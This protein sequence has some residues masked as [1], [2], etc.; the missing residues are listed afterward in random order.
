MV[1]SSDLEK[2]RFRKNVTSLLV[3]ERVGSGKEERDAVFYTISL[4]NPEIADNELFVLLN[5]LTEGEAIA[6]TIPL[7][8][9]ARAS[10][11]LS[12]IMRDL[13]A[14]TSVRVTPGTRLYLPNGQ[15]LINVHGEV[16]C[17]ERGCSIHHPSNHHMKQFS[18]VYNH[19]DGWMMRVCDH[20]ITASGPLMTRSYHQDILKDAHTLDHACDGCCHAPDRKIEQNNDN[21]QPAVGIQD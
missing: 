1:T 10:K 5:Q 16:D 17:V 18:Q 6:Y 7:D 21:E 4:E 3:S 20:G 13:S 9:P 8:D 19:S 2:R 14:T 11:E 12:L 15:L